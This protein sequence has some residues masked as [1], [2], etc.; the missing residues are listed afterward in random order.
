MCMICTSYYMPTLSTHTTTFL[1]STLFNSSPT[2]SRQR[3][4][5]TLP[6]LPVTEE[7]TAR[8]VPMD[9]VI[10]LVS[11]TV[12]SATKSSPPLTA[13]TT[14]GGI[15][16]RTQA[17]R[18]SPP[19][20]VAVAGVFVTKS[21]VTILTGR[22]VKVN[23]NVS[24]SP[25]MAVAVAGVKITREALVVAR[26]GRNVT[27]KRLVITLVVGQAVMTTVLIIISLSKGLKV[28]S[29]TLNRTRL[30]T[31]I[32]RIWMGMYQLNDVLYELKVQYAG[33][34]AGMEGLS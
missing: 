22:A 15:V 6:T 17:V 7:V 10:S 5:P 33:G 20:V 13:M 30:T 24:G 8:G 34:S 28:M 19:M 12:V 23:L 1:L 16:N 9:G 26:V 11:G 27:V 14:A 18:G 21:T 2:Y 25:P 3:R 29:I 32:T 4:S 31:T